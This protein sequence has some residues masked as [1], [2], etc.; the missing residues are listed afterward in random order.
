MI[1]DSPLDASW[2]VQSNF[3]LVTGKIDDPPH[4]STYQFLLPYGPI[5]TF[6]GHTWS[7][8]VIKWELCFWRRLDS[9]LEWLEDSAS[10]AKFPSISHSSHSSPRTPKLVNSFIRKHKSCYLY[11]HY[12][13]SYR[14]RNVLIFKTDVY[15]TSTQTLV[16]TCYRIQQYPSV[17]KSVHAVQ[18]QDLCL[19]LRT[20]HNK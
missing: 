17:K 18:G 14:R 8:V 10:G 6:S 5:F 3:M 11:L 19:L 2:L 13:S 20:I 12:C 16:P 7:I 4:P 1:I 15:L 9:F